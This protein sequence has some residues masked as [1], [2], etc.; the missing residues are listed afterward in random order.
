M[1]LATNRPGRGT[2]QAAARPETGPAARPGT[3]EG[4]G[5]GLRG[6]IAAE[7]TKTWTV[8]ATWWNL[9]GACVLMALVAL[10]MSIYVAN[11]N[12]NDDPADDEGV[13]SIGSMAIQSV[14]IAQFPL[15]ALA[16]LLIT[17][18]YSSGAIRT[19]LQCTPRHGRMLASKAVVA[20]VVCGAAG[21]VMAVA[22]SAVGAVML[23]RWGSFRP[24]EWTGAMLSVGCYMALIGVFALGV[25]TA[26]RSAVGS[27]VVVFLVVVMIPMLL[28]ASDIDLLIDIAACLPGTAGGAFMRGESETY[29]SWLGLPILAAWSAAALATGYAVLRRRDA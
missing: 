11:G 20:A 28:G 8:R 22:G 16:M 12:T 15:I 17:A 4:S 23:G 29:P 7:W 2:G 27:L 26:L 25:G 14:D 10:Q 5:G 3:G 1:S 19:T 6:A 18:E 21:I 9:V 24:G 13:V